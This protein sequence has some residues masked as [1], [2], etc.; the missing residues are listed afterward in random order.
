[1]NKILALVL[2]ALA[3]IL[4]LKAFSEPLGVIV[5]ILPQQYFV[6]AMAGEAV[7]VTV[8]VEPGADPHVYEPSP[9]QMVALSNADL[10]LAVGVSFEDV[11]LPRFQDAN[12]AMTVVHCDAGVDKLP[13]ASHHH[14]EAGAEQEHHHDE[15]AGHEDEHGHEHGALDPHIWLS[16]SNA[17]IMAENIYNALAAA[18]PGNREVYR[19][20]YQ[21][22]VMD[23]QAVDQEIR[24]LFADIPADERSF[25]VFHPAWGYFAHEYGLNQ[26][27]VEVEGREPSAREMAELV[28]QAQ[29]QHVSVIF[30]QPQMSEQTARTIADEIGADVAVLDPLARDWPANMLAAAQALAQAMH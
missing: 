11:W 18:D 29:E 16:P 23:I 27:A 1:M 9:R 25:L 3:T 6:A 30:V 26:V 13:M 21:A 12:P 28:R 17:L 5:S 20:G 14:D 8:M 7:E 24:S 15:A 2:L 4:P 22:L 10:Y 19:V